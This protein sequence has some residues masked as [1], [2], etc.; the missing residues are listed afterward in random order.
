MVDTWTDRECSLYFLR[1]RVF[2]CEGAAQHVHLSCVCLSVS[3]LNFSLLLL[4]HVFQRY[5]MLYKLSSSQDLVVGL[6][7]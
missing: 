1:P 3:K 4:L 5:Y 7:L 6:V 2:S